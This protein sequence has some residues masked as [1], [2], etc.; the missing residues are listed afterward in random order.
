MYYALERTKELQQLYPKAKV[1]ENVLFTEDGNIYASAG[2]ASGI[3]MALYIVEKI[4]GSF[5]AHKVA[6]ELVIYT[7]RSG[8]QHQHSE[9]LNYRNHIHTGIHKTQDWLHE[10][11]HKKVSLKFLAG[12][13]NMSDRNF[14]RVFKKETSLTVNEYITLLRKEK[15]TQ[16][17]NNPDMS[18]AQIAKQCGLKSER[19]VSRLINNK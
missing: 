4:M 10:N 9:L 3:D 12:I 18:R 17:L 16:L 14:T 2:I 7:R 15:I 11:L 8:N 1:V 6:R 13:A 5:F 19:Q